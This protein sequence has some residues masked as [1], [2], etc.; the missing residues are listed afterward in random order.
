MTTL[1]NELLQ[2]IQNEERNFELTKPE[3]IDGTVVGLVQEDRCF[4]C[5]E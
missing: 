3:V 2:P 1:T 4:K 5:T